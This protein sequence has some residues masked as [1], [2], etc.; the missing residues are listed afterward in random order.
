M[1][2]GT[3][4][5]GRVYKSI[6]GTKSFKCINNDYLLKY[7]QQGITMHVTK[8]LSTLLAQHTDPYSTVE[9]EPLVDHCATYLKSRDDYLDL[10]KYVF[11]ALAS[12]SRDMRRTAEF[13]E[14]YPEFSRK[15]H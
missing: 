11:N 5:E 7:E 12:I 1:N 4:S 2:T 9:T 15:E 10:K 14:Q 13:N 8:A 3:I 6:D